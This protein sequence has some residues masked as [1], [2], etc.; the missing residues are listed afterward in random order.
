MSYN[1]T[2][3]G[4]DSLEKKMLKMG[5]NIEN[6]QPAFK[7]MQPK[8]INE[9]KENFPAKGKIL[10][11]PWSERKYKYPWPLLVKTGKM[12][13]TWLGK[14][15]KRSLEIKN[16]VSYAKYHNFGTDKLP[17]RKL[18]GVGKSINKIIKEDIIEW[19]L[20][21]FNFKF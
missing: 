11:S 8:I 4:L 18:V 10:E 12:K 1:I 9:Y 6:L 15:K 16:P 13:K 19:I 20:K 17:I 7:K 3:R 21:P 5:S 14:T 2:V